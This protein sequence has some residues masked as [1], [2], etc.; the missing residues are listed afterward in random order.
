MFSKT[1][2]KTI[3][4]AA[5]A[6]SVAAIGATSASAGGYGNGFGNGY[7]NN[8]SNAGYQR[9]QHFKVQKHVWKQ[10]VSWCYDRFR[11]YRSHDNTYQP[12]GGPRQQCWSPFVRR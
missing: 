2:V 5:L 11:S 6:A 12:Y 9:Q 10:H 4:L 8:H 3:T 7:G 1:I